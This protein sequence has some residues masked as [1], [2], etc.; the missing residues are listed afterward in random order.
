MATFY[1]PSQAGWNDN[2]TLGSAAQ[3]RLKLEKSY[4]AAANQST[5]TL[6]MQGRAPN[7]GGRYMLLNNALVKLNNTTLLSG[8]G[9]ATSSLD[10]YI[11]FGG[12]SEWHNLCSKATG[13]TQSWTAT[14]DHAADGTATATLSVTARLYRSDSYYMSFY[15]LSGSQALDETR[16]FTLSISAGTGSTITVKRGSATLSDGATLTYGDQL[17]I[18]FSAQTGYDLTAHTVNGANFTSGGA[19]TVTGTVAVASTAAKKTY[20]LSIS[21]GTGSTI[22]V[23]RGSS[24]LS[25]GATLTH[26]DTLT[27]SFTAQSGYEL[28][29][30]T[31]NGASFTSGGTHTVTAAVTVSASARRLGLVRLDTGSAIQRYRLLLDTGSAIVPV[32]IFLDLGDRITEAGI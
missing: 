7:Y 20:T 23:K 19:H 28:L 14:V 25:N 18:S 26:G 5:L 9:N 16:H 22:T 17:T 12:D 1:V 10:Y 32:R 21:A 15:N 13:Q 29:T 31:V 27:I 8:G 24:T 6:T 3:L 11:D 30:H 2:G 4:N